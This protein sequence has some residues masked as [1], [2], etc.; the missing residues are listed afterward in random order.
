MK[1]CKESILALLKCLFPIIS[2][3]TVERSSGLAAL[4]AVLHFLCK[5]FPLHRPSSS[6]KI[7]YNKIFFAIYF[8]ARRANLKNKK[9]KEQNFLAFRFDFVL[10][11]A[12]YLFENCGAR[13]AAFKP[14]FFLSFILES[15]V[16]KPAFLRAALVSGSAS[17]RARE[18]P[19]RI[20]PA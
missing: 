15:R 12:N 14:Y 5:T 4:F 20:A 2:L 8:Y 19:W 18:I 3:R 1:K 13:R 7:F 9:S 17:K 16:K 11:F 10:L 6:R